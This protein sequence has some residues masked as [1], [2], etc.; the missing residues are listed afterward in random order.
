MNSKELL[1]EIKKILANLQTIYNTRFNQT[2]TFRVFRN[3]FTAQLDHLH[4]PRD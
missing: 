2:E 1:S 3:K 4:Q